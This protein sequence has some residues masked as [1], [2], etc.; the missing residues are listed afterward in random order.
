M[1]EEFAASGYENND[2]FGLGHQLKHYGYETAF[3]H[4]GRN[5]TM[6][7]DFLSKLSGMEQY[8]GLNEYPENGDYDG[9]WGIF[10]EQFLQFTANK[11]QDLKPPF[12]AMVFT[13][14][15]HQPYTIP[16]QH[17]GRFPKGTLDIHESI[18]YADYSLRQFFK[19]ASGMPWFTNTIFVITGDHTQMTDQPAYQTPWGYFD[20]PLIIYSPTGEYPKANLERFCQHAD[21][22][23]SLLDMLGLKPV[24]HS[25]LGRSIFGQSQGIV[26]NTIDAKPSLLADSIMV[27]LSETGGITVIPFLAGKKVD[28]SVEKA[29]IRQLKAHLQYFNNSLINNHWY[30]DQ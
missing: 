8:F 2:W 6:S 10:D 4:G 18:G 17:K 27:Q 24:K 19:K 9:N 26:L 1:N 25:C 14:S 22:G 15:S 11:L 21:V 23:P 28:S 12:A 7:F 30:Q 29:G 3:F 13:L 5:G 20:V 16:D